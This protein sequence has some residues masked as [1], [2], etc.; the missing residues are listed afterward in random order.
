MPT[1][2][3]I[4]HRG[5]RLL[6]V[7]CTYTRVSKVLLST[8]KNNNKYSLEYTL[9]SWKL[10]CFS[11]RS[12]VE[13]EHANEHFPIFRVWESPQ[14][15]RVWRD[16]R[17][18][19]PSTFLF[20][21]HDTTRRCIL[22]RA[23]D[24]VG[25]RRLNDVN[26]ECWETPWTV[27]PSLRLAKRATKMHKVV[28]QTQQRPAMTAWRLHDTRKC[29]GTRVSFISLTDEIWIRAS[30]CRTGKSAN[31][32]GEQNN[33]SLTHHAAVSASNSYLD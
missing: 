9:F 30:A 22:N 1:T 31:R 26:Q 28:D 7:I 19:A 33:R 27:S 29:V 12:H 18:G 32:R 5:R 17:P 21:R 15:S 20:P 8:K 24:A 2:R 16:G 14:P 10:K 3:A 23:T 13:A 25:A 11:L 6:R 4:A